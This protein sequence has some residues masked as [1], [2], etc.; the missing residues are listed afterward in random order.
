VLEEVG[1]DMVYLMFSVNAKKK[2]RSAVMLWIGVM[3]HVESH[4][5]RTKLHDF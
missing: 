2:L 5:L 1:Y 3:C 4:Q